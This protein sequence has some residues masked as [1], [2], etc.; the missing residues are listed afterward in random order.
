MNDILIIDLF[1]ADIQRVKNALYAKF[2]M[3][4]LG[5]CVYYLDMII[6]RDRS[7]RTLHLR[8]STYIKR[9]LK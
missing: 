4:N 1:K 6:S 2:K 9:F 3:N 5:S 8:Q 7:N